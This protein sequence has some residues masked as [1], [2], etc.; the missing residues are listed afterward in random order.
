MKNKKILGI[1]LIV[2]AFVGLTLWG[3]FNYS[4][5]EEMKKQLNVEAENKCI[6]YEKTIA[7]LQN[8]LNQWQDKEQGEENNTE[9]VIGEKAWFFLQ[10]FYCSTNQAEDVNPLMTS[11]A[12]KKLYSNVNDNG[13]GIG[14]NENYQVTVKKQSIYYTKLSS[15]TADVFIMADLNVKTPANTSTSPLLFHAEM[16]Y[17]DGLW[18]VS[19]ILLNSTVRY[20]R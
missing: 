15:T 7:R 10:T 19:K 18:L 9:K 2:V 16:T 6:E 12:Y 3:L 13:A 4:S 11:E 17:T 20:N 1:I 14:T 8:E 5:R